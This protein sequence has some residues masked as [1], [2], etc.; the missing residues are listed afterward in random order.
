MF[1]VIVNREMFGVGPSILKCLILVLI[2]WNRPYVVT[3]KGSLRDY[4]WSMADYI[5]LIS[6]NGR[7]KWVVLKLDDQK[8]IFPYLQ[9]LKPYI[10]QKK[11]IFSPYFYFVI[12]LVWFSLLIEKPVILFHRR[13]GYVK[14]VFRNYIGS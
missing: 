10:C 7:P 2:F 8:R 13:W 5:G 9:G 14:M 12:Y 11:T 1:L 6:E 4:M 3:M